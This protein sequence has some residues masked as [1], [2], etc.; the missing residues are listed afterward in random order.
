MLGEHP[1]MDPRPARELRARLLELAVEEVEQLELLVGGAG[2]DGPYGRGDV[3]E[4]A[5]APS[6]S[7]RASRRRCSSRAA[8]M[9]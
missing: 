2:A 9:R 1:R 4:P 7:R 8:T 5:L 3:R 6:C